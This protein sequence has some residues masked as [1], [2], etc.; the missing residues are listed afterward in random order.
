MSA[1]DSSAQC[2]RCFNNSLQRSQIFKC[3]NTIIFSLVV[4]PRE[5]SKEFLEYEYT[6]RISMIREGLRRRGEGVEKGE[7]DA[8]EARLYRLGRH[9][10]ALWGGATPLLLDR[11]CLW[12]AILAVRQPASQ[13]AASKT[14]GGG[15]GNYGSSHENR[16]RSESWNTKGC[17]SWKRSLYH[18]NV[19]TKIEKM[20]GGRGFFLRCFDLIAW[21]WMKEE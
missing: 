11:G 17:C 16:S 21:R 6:R 15:G 20:G 2:F 3:P 18:G 13:P 12:L 7:E 1:L 10:E 5:I 4:E 8:E 9:I 14:R 19:A